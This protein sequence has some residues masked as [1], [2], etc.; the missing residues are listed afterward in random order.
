MKKN[1]LRE[2][3]NAGKPTIGTHVVTTSPEIVEVIG[4]SGAFDYIEL[5]GQYAVWSLPALDNFARAVELFPHMSSMMKVEQEPRLFITTRSL[6]AGIQNI[7]FA[8]CRS[9]AE[10]RE[11]VRMVRAATPED[12]GLQGCVI[13]RMGGYVI[14]IGNEAWVK[15]LREAVIVVMIEKESA[16]EQLEE[17]LSVEGVDMVQFGPCDYSLNTGRAGKWED[18]EVQRK[19]REMIELALKKGVHPRVELDGFEKAPQFIEMGVRHFCIGWE[20][21]TIF[22]WCKH[23]GEGLRELLAKA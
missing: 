8:D 12:G 21:F 13:R 10:V 9:A 11:C 23:H 15:A 5:C 19:Q 18:P 22:Q 20:L 1:R 4:H 17:I 14:D 7:L 16:M 2:L 6:G 3:L